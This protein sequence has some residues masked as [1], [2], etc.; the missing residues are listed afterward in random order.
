KGTALD[1]QNY[2][3]TAGANTDAYAAILRLSTRYPNNLSFSSIGGY[4]SGK[5]GICSNI[6]GVKFDYAKFYNDADSRD[7]AGRWIY[8]SPFGI[9]PT[10]QTLN[11]TGVSSASASPV[12]LRNLRLNKFQTTFSLKRPSGATQTD[13][14]FCFDA[15]DQ[16]DLYYVTIPHAG[17]PTVPS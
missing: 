5:V 6:T 1:T 4:P 11:L 9:D 15:Q 10:S 13:I 17:T 12:Y 2:T 14:N 16:D 7:M 3:I 8:N